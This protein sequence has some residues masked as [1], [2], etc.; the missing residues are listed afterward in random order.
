M[1]ASHPGVRDAAVVVHEAVP[2]DRRLVGY[3]VPVDVGDP[4]GAVELAGHCGTRL[5]EYMVP[6][7]FI[8]IEAIPLNANG[9]LDRTALPAP[10]HVPDEDRTAPRG[11]VEERIAALWTDLFGLRTGVHNDFFKVGGNSILAIRLIA[12]IQQEFDVDLPVRT[13]FERPTIAGLAEAVE[14]RIRAEIAELSDADLAAARTSLKED[15]A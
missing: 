5:P 7:A 10:D 13:V 3:V 12:G 4:P 6:S 1:L 15:R 11:V 2:G 8:V 14:F 9:K